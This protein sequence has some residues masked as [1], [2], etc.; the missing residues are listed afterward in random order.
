MKP[1]TTKSP[2]N[3]NL[4]LTKAIHPRTI[5]I[6]FAAAE[7]HE[8]FVAGDFNQWNPKGTPLNKDAQ[9]VWRTQLQVPPGGHEYRLVVDNQWQDDPHAANY[10][11][12]P[13]GSHNAF[14]QVV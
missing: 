11:P 10:I 14:V 5:A 13:F 8:V 7:A 3:G 2:K 1:T 9:G 4:S 6:S 12:N